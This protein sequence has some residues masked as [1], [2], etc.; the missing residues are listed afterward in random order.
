MNELERKIGD[1]AFAGCCTNRAAGQGPTVI[2]AGHFAVFTAGARA[3]D[4]L[5]EPRI[6]A[7]HTDMVDFSRESWI[8]AC[9]VVAQGDAQ[10]GR[11]P[12]ADSAR[13]APNLL[14]LVDD[15]QFVRPALPDR[16]AGERQ[17]GRAHV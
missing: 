15:I 6:I 14:L 1:A 4:L 8:A 3:H 17:I 11:S 5:D 2:L 7:A 10:A 12:H 13:E 16:G 9:N